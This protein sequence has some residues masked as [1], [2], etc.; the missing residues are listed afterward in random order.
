[1]NVLWYLLCLLQRKQAFLSRGCI[2]EHKFN[3]YKLYAV[4]C[5]SCLRVDWK[6]L[7]KLCAQLDHKFK[8]RY[9]LYALQCISCLKVNWKLLQKLCTQL[10]SV[11]HGKL[12]RKWCCTK[13]ELN[14]LEMHSM[15]NIQRPLYIPVW[16]R[17]CLIVH[18][19]R[20]WQVTPNQLYNT[21]QSGSKNAMLITWGW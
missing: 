5:I 3:R 12:K 16:V 7:Q 4:Q 10:C 9:K 20:F 1:M 14:V 18:N 15:Y 6:W 8:N 13:F 21:S 2:F 19:A 11:I 17:K